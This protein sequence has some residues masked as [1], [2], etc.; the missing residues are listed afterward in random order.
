MNALSFGLSKQSSPSC[1]SQTRLHNGAISA[2]RCVAKI[3]VIPK[4]VFSRLTM[5][6]MSL[7]P[8]RSRWLVGSSRRST[9]GCIAQKHASATRCFSPPESSEIR[10]FR[11]PCKPTC[12][13]A[14]SMRG[15]MCS[16]EMQ[17]FSSPNAISSSTRVQKSCSSGFWNKRPTC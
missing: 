11:K 9:C 4:S 12:A 17:R 15:A 1:M 6:R 14:S 7:V 2:V 5:S 8:R 16:G 10:R 3:V 13:S